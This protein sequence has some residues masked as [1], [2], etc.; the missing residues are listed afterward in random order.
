MT[1]TLENFLVFAV[2]GGKKEGFVV[3]GSKGERSVTRSDR[4]LA[5]AAVLM[6]V[7][8]VMAQGPTGEEKAKP[9][10]KETRGADVF[11]MA[12]VH[13]FHLEIAAKE[14]DKMQPTGG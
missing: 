4:F 1:R 13:E 8:L 10:G 2:P 3:P 7:S 11:G 9:S 12:R 14:Y 5:L 6:C